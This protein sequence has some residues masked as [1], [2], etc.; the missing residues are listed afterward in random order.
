MMP[1]VAL[2]RPRASHAGE[3]QEPLGL[4]Y[5]AGQLTADGIPCA[6]FDR[7]L[8]RRTRRDTL[9]AVLAYAPT[10][11][12][13][14]VMSMEDAPDALRLISR[15]RSAGVRFV[16]GGLLV[17]TAPDVCRALFPRQ[18][19]LVRGE[20]EG[21]IT[22]VAREEAGGA[23]LMD[24]TPSSPDDWPVPQR[25]QLEEYLTSG[26]VMNLRASRGCPGACLFCATPSLPAPY[27]RWRG[28]ALPLVVDEMEHLARRAVAGGF[29]PVFNFVDDD[30]GSLTRVEAL[31]DLIRGRGLLAAFSLE[32]RG[33]AL[34]G[35]SDLAARFA[36]LKAAGLCRVFVGL[37]NLNAATL[38]QWGKPFP[39]EEVLEAVQAM[40]AAGILVHTGYIL[41]HQDITL[42]VL[43]AQV[44]ALHR[45]DLFSPK[46]A[47]SRLI[48]Y[49]GSRICPPDVKTPR[50]QPL[51]PH[52]EAA[53]QRVSA[54]AGSLMEAWV[55]LAERL[56]DVACRAH[57]SGDPGELVPLTQQLRAINQQAY[58]VTMQCLRR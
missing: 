55:P 26:G 34:V 12:G 17:T 36:R 46:V 24:G 42:P 10:L 35:Q 30:S 53:W 31:C 57:L 39:P 18:V 11:I 48:L 8:D 43:T 56:P 20:G 19:T 9:A 4:E 27:G 49:P 13:L 23:L 33:L 45:L 21:I 44:Q 51:P 22:S 29:A 38:R 41:W 16:V 3:F 1:K 28:R 47:L 32:L 54:A 7:E 58:E 2:I 50:P 5:L 52:C 40:R 37:E 25:P 6:I 14:T 15:L